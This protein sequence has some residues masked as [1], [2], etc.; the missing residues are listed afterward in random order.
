MQIGRDRICTANSTYLPTQMKT[1]QTIA[2]SATASSAFVIGMH[3]APQTTY[4]V[5]AGSALTVILA[6]VITFGTQL[7]REMTDS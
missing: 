3:H 2:I 5:F 6:L 1:S 4:S 7:I